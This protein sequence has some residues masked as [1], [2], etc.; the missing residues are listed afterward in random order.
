MLGQFLSERGLTVSEAGDGK[1][2]FALLKQTRVDAIILDVMLPGDDG[3]TLCR[4]LRTDSTVP[5]ILLTAIND[6]AD[7]IAGLELGADDYVAK[8]FDPRELLRS[9]SRRATQA[10]NI[11]AVGT[12]TGDLQLQRLGIGSAAANAA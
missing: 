12:R 11:P 7:R 2:M 10:G 5:V 9:H 8:P 4:R 1:S 3:F 6:A